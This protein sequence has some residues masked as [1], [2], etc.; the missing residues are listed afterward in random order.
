MSKFIKFMKANKIQK[1]NEMHP[2][3]ASLCDDTGKPLDFEFR[4][5]TSAENENIRAACTKDV[6][7]TGKPGMYRPKIDTSAYVKKLI[8]ASIVAP[9]MHDADLQDSYGVKT[10]EDLLMAMVDNPGE[11]QNLA[12]YVQQLQGFNVSFE[13]KVN[14][15]KN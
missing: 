15:A 4:H 10:P 5:I 3:T 12:A 11:Y 1:A 14:E 2:V 6:P 7:V 8:C 9:D 13:D